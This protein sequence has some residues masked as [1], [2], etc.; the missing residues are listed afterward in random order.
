M[1][2]SKLRRLIQEILINQNL[3]VIENSSLSSDSQEFY[4]N[5]HGNKMSFKTFVETEVDERA[6]YPMEDILSWMK[7]YNINFDDKC[8]WITKDPKD[9]FRYLAFD[10]G[11]FEDNSNEEDETYGNKYSVNDLHHIRVTDGF[12]IP[13]SDDGDGGFLFVYKNK[14]T[15]QFG[16]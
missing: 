12:L 10:D 3:N 15:K 2:E 1:N 4:Y 11:Y 5:T 16:H 13:E 9:A 8:I 7:K 14:S 6:N